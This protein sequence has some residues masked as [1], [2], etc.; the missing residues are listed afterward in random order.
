MGAGLVSEL[1]ENYAVKELLDLGQQKTCSE[2][3]KH[4]ACWG[5][6]CSALPT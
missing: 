3:R 1:D 2:G 6:L 5:Q 4:Q